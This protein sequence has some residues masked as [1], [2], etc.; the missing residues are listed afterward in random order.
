MC[1]VFGKNFDLSAIL[2]HGSMNTV[3]HS[4]ELN[5]A[6]TL[7]CKIFGNKLKDNLPLLSFYRAM[8]YLKQQ[9]NISNQSKSTFEWCLEDV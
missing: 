2:S 4:F 1:S 8:I 5:L 3:L 7:L 9:I 6:L